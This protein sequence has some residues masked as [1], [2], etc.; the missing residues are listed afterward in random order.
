M[1]SDDLFLMCASVILSE[2]RSKHP[3]ASPLLPRRTTARDHDFRYHL[4]MN[5]NV[6]VIDLK[7]YREVFKGVADRITILIMES[8]RRNTN[9]SVSTYTTK[10]SQRTAA[11]RR[12]MSQEETIRCGIFNMTRKC[13]VVCCLSSDVVSPR[14]TAA[15][16]AI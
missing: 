1:I 2:D 11:E 3:I 8:L 15:M 13:P 12:E 16:A 6:G 5:R 14:Q 10:P 9:T 7:F 4:E